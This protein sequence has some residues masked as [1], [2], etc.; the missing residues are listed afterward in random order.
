MCGGCINMFFWY[1][2]VNS[3]FFEGVLTDC[4]NSFSLHYKIDKQI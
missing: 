4:D 3:I 1:A 2:V